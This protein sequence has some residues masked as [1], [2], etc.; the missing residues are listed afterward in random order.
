MIRCDASMIRC[1]VSMIWLRSFP[2]KGVDPFIFLNTFPSGGS[3]R[4]FFGVRRESDSFMSCCVASKTLLASC[5]ESSMSCGSELQMRFCDR[6]ETKNIRSHM[7]CHTLFLHT[8][9][10]CILTYSHTNTP[11]NVYRYI[12]T[13]LHTHACN[14]GLT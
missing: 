7:D 6:N 8:F 9:H 12:S 13:N 1:D 11:T 4:F 10:S 3:N 5:A 2:K 14:D